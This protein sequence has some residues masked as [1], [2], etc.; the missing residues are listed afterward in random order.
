MA[1]I[2]SQELEYMDVLR[3]DREAHSESYSYSIKHARSE[4]SRIQRDFS[5]NDLQIA[6]FWG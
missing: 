2:L 1:R 5:R 4:Q 6:T 3:E